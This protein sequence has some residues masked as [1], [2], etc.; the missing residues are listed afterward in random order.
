METQDIWNA[1]LG[2]AV[3]ILGIWQGIQTGKQNRWS[4][5]HERQK[6]DK[7]F[8]GQKMKIFNDANAVFSNFWRE[9]RMSYE[10]LFNFRIAVQNAAIYFDEETVS[11][12]NKLEEEISEAAS[13]WEMAKYDG[14]KKFEYQTK[15]HELTSAFMLRQQEESF[16]KQMMPAL[17]VVDGQE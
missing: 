16:R 3:L 14:Q 1:V 8:H 13:Y 12:L 6:T 5:Q 2:L 15:A 10:D 7:E 9:G 17:K 11:Y 4:R